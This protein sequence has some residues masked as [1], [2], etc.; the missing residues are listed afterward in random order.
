M[1]ELVNPKRRSSITRKVLESETY[2]KG[3]RTMIITIVNIIKAKELQILSCPTDCTWV[4]PVESE[5]PEN[6]F[7]F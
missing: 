6:N 2:S 7:F 1:E 5:L 3:S 4:G